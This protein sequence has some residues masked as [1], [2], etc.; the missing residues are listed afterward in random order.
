MSLPVYNIL[1][2]VGV[3]FLCLGF[4]ALISAKTAKK[5]MMFHGIGL[6]VLLVSGFGQLAKLGMTAHMPTWA[7]VKAVL[8]LALG[9]LPVLAKRQVL[10]RQVTVA[11]AFLFIAVAAYLGCSFYLGRPMPF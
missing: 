4:F 5:G 6:L 11:I 3:L 2:L 10:S 9:V 8:W 7:I 1:H